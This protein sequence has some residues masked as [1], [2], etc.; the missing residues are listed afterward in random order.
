MR[1]ALSILGALILI[2]LSGCTT[3]VDMERVKHPSWSI[4]IL[5][6]QVSTRIAQSGSTDK[7]YELIVNVLSG[8]LGGLYTGLVVTRYVRI[9]ELRNE[10]I[11]IVQQ[12]E[13]MDE[14]GRGFQVNDPSSNS[15]I[16][17]SSDL[18]RLGHQAGGDSIGKVMKEIS[19]YNYGA[20]AG[21]VSCH[22]YDN[23]MKKW[24]A[25]I[26]T[27]PAARRVLWRPWGKI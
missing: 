22:Q 9:S 16:Y 6:P 11:R 24:Q 12:I 20:K 26:R 18:Y 5:S 15:L 7:L 3:A 2:L 14:P 1:N 17:I 23:Q 27:L 13:Y 8:L 4:E 25:I 19:E 10:A 21:R